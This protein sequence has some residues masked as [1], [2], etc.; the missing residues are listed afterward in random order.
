VSQ[1]DRYIEKFLNYLKVEKNAS[2][3]T[4]R[5]YEKDLR[6]LKEALKGT[7]W[8]KA[9]LLA[10]RQFVADQRLKNLSKVTVARRVATTRSFFRFLF[11]DGYVKVNPALTL[12]RPKLDKK[13]PHFL[14]VDE[15]TRLMEAP[16]G[17]GE[18]PARDRAILETLYSTGLRVSELVGL[19]VKDA[20]LISQTVRVIGKGRKE[21]IVPIGSHSVKAI[22]AYMKTLGPEGSSGEKPLFQNLRHGRLT[23]RSVRRILNK[24]IIEASIR[25]KI[26]P[27]ALRHSF[28]THLLD[29]GADLRSVQELLGHSNLAT[30]Q[31]YTHVTT[32]RLKKVYESAHPRAK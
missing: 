15:T 10:L 27:H 30:T 13:L 19:K 6:L 18:M 22:H 11:R 7:T 17:A 5:N 12:T 28:A 4:L 14:S 16:K 29:A 9:D 2:A 24:Y 26:S 32:E 8:E 3:H 23:D 25:Q 1:D 21:R 31:V 20:D